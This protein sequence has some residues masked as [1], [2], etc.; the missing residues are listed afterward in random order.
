ML[1]CA[2]KSRVDAAFEA[3][4]PRPIRDLILEVYP[5]AT[6]DCHGRF[7]APYDG[8]ECPITGK[9]FRAGE[10]LPVNDPDEA[11]R[12]T[13][14][15][16]FPIAVHPTNGEVFKWQGTRAQNIAAWGELIAQS[17]AYDAVNSNHVGEVGKMENIEDLS[18]Q[19]IKAF[20]GY[21]GIVFIYLFKDRRGNVV[22]YKGSKRLRSGSN[23]YLDRD[24]CVGDEVNLRCKIKA[25]GEREGV[26]QTLIERPKVLK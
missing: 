16:N 21:Y 1:I 8:Y 9:Q 22:V 14:G 2:D 19:F 4:A 26:K 12:A 24:L 15:S 18:I 17:R 23:P 11:L 20:D 6:E 10:Y 7:H 13:G 3:A 5:D 25:H